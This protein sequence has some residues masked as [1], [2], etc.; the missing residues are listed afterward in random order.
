MRSGVDGGHASDPVLLWL[1]CR[2]AAVALIQRLAW[3]LPYATSVS[4]KRKKKRKSIGLELAQQNP[5][6]GMNMPTTYTPIPIRPSFCPDKTT[7]SF[8]IQCS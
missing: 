1:W 4:L 7:E 2:P 6:A 5:A 3:E 8:L